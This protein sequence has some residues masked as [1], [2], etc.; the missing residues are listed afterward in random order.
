MSKNN[1]WGRSKKG[2][3]MSKNNVWAPTAHIERWRGETLIRVEMR[4]LSGIDPSYAPNAIVRWMLP[5]DAEELA[6]ALQN[7]ADATKKEEAS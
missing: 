5:A 7:A 1:V 6:L 3:A 4:V 2:T